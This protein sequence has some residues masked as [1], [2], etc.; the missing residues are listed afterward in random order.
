MRY[1][2]IDKNRREKTRMRE[3]RTFHTTSKRDPKDPLPNYHKTFLTF[4]GPRLP[5]EDEPPAPANDK[6]W[7]TAPAPG[8]KSEGGLKVKSWIFV[9]VHL[10]TKDGA[11]AR[12]NGRVT[13]G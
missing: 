5:A 6:S 13:T 10:Q 4:P 2:Q 7:M 8:G 9:R 12:D 1:L 3:T 11:M